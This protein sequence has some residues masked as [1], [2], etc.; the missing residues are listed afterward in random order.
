[1]Q[2]PALWDWM[3]KN[4]LNQPGQKAVVV[5]HTFAAG[6]L[7]DWNWPNA[8]F[9]C[10]LEIYQGARGSYEAWRL[11]EREKRGPTQVDEAG[12][13]AQ[14]ALARGNTYGFVSFSD[15]GS[16]HNSWA[17][18][19]ARA[20]SREALLDAMLARR[21]YAASDEILI[22]ASAGGHMVGEEFDA[23][24]ASPPEITASIEAPDTILRLDVVKDGNYVYTV[25]PGARSATLRWRDADARPGRSY[26]YLRVFQ[27]DPENP[28]G[29]PEI[30]WTSP[31]YVRYQ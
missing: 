12:H 19:W 31:F 21:T 14:D 15:H 13:Y 11:P 9:D 22:R 28:G 30:A 10:L 29:D 5:P 1:N 26:Y 20:V 3:E 23:R 7:A 16:T 27:R 25:S 2:P 18:V 6:P 17:A 4:V 24:V 8:R